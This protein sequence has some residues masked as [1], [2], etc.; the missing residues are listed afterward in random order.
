M[1]IDDLISR[2]AAISAAEKES[3]RYGAYGYMDTKSIIDMLED[4]P[5]VQPEPRWIP[6]K[7]RPM[8]EEERWNFEEHTGIQLDD[9]DAVFFDC[10]MPEDGQ[11]IWIS[12][13][14]GNVF[15]DFC[16]ND[17]DFLGLEGNGDWLDVTAWMPMFVPEPWRGEYDV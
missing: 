16:E 12:T 11:R 17:G 14:H 5:P 15:E 9:E 6:V 2:K 8:T 13:I 3:Q 10:K 7:T 1:K 4:L